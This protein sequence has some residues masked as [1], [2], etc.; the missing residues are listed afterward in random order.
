MTAKSPAYHDHP[1]QRLLLNFPDTIGK[2]AP[3][4]SYSWGQ[5]G[6]G[7]SGAAPGGTR[8]IAQFAP[9][10]QPS[11]GLFAPGYPLV[12][13]ERERLRIYNFPTGVNYIYTPRSFE[14][15]GFPELK[16]LARD[17]ITR[18]C[19]ETRK[20][21]IEK[22]QWSIKPR[23]EKDAARN[24]ETRIQQLSEFWAYPDGITPFAT[25]LRMLME[26]VLV[27][28]CPALEPR[29][30]RGGDLIGFDVIDGSTIKVLIDDTGRRPRPPRQRFVA[31]GRWC[32]TGRRSEALCRH[33]HRFRSADAR[34]LGRRGFAARDT[35]QLPDK[36]EV[37]H[38]PTKVGRALVASHRARNARGRHRIRNCRRVRT[39]AQ[40]E[41]D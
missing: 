13:V 11:G 33:H 35:G 7:P 39:H 29:R 36:S 25:R 19:S 28:D 15:I 32:T 3:I 6:S 24:A 26:Q 38:P 9:V 31:H 12:P 20:D 41:V 18:L 27:A 37:L 8:D 16:A 21:Q 40:H 5:N 23:N 17:D 2:G 14:E 4:L 1:A 34:G 30:N 22:L 10:F